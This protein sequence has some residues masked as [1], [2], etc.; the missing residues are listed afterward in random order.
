M[1]RPYRP[2][3]LDRLRHITAVCF[4]G[5]AID[6]NIEDRFGPIGGRDW[7]WR[8]LRH[9][10][11][12]TAGEN[13]RGVFVWEEDGETVAYVT[14]RLDRESRIGWIPNLAVLPEFRSRGIARSLLEHLLNW[15][16]AEGMEA[17]KIETLEQNA[18]GNRFYPSLGFEEV[19]R[20]VHFVKQLTPP[21]Q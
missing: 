10:D 1:I 2:E 15:F 6:K 20:Q 19:A 8:K 14:G 7:R 17:A 4:E 13:A 9:I 3:D 12:D 21:P 18:V 11:A 16:T 5:V